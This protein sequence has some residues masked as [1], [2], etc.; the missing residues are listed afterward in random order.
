MQGGWVF[1]S[2]RFADGQQRLTAT[3]QTDLGVIAM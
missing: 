1:E 2:L 3:I